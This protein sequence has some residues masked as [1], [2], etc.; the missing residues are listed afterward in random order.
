MTS[1]ALEALLAQATILLGA[2]VVV[3]LASHRLRLPPIVG[4]L[5]TGALIGPSGALLE[6][7]TA[8][9]AAA[10]GTSP[11]APGGTAASG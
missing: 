7:E 6:G 9:A 8:G 1:L 11:P 5:A 4:L 2:A 3:L 10:A